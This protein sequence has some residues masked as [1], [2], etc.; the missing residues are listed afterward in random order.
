MSLWDHSY[1]N[2]HISEGDGGG[3]SDDVVIVIMEYLLPIPYK[4][5]SHQ[6]CDTM[7]TLECGAV[8]VAT[9]EV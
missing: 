5:L 1:S 8:S 4:E 6:V 2:N 3:G 7:E 9:M